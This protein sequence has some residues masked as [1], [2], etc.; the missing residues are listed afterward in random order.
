MSFYAEL[1]FSMTGNG[2]LD[3]ESG[4]IYIA[5][6]TCKG[7]TLELIQMVGTAVN[8]PDTWKTGKIDH[9]ALNVENVQDAFVEAR[10][11]GY[12]L[13]DFGVKELPLFEKG[14]R[15]FTIKGPNGEK[16]EFNQ[17]NKF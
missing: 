14:C 6:M 9:I 13:L 8:D 17:V 5:F 3:T 16:I 2:Y 1:G 12:E 7:F 10:S 11:C 15:F 4:R